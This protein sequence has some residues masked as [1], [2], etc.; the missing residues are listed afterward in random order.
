MSNRSQNDNSSQPHRRR[1]ISFVERIQ[2]L[3]DIYILINGWHGEPRSIWR[4]NI[5]WVRINRRLARRNII[6]ALLATFD[7]HARRNYNPV[8]RFALQASE[9]P[10]SSWWTSSAKSSWMTAAPAASAFECRVSLLL[11]RVSNRVAGEGHCF[12]FREKLGKDGTL[13]LSIAIIWERKRDRWE[14]CTRDIWSSIRNHREWN[15]GEE[16]FIGILVIFMKGKTV[17]AREASFSQPCRFVR[18]LER[19]MCQI[20]LQLIRARY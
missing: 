20:Y 3:R 6:F 8:K 4:G 10:L 14:V 15:I 9:V 1:R 12:P 13:A 2:L 5:S 18:Q 11:G 16:Q 7:M 17:C 19:F